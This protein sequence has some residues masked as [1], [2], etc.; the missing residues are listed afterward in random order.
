MN[1]SLLIFPHILYGLPV[2]IHL[3]SENIILEPAIEIVTAENKEAQ[4]QD[5]NID[6]LKQHLTTEK[7]VQ[8]FSEAYLLEIKNKLNTWIEQKNILDPETNISTLAVQ[9][10]IPQHHLSYYFNNI[11][12]I[13]FTDWRN[14]LK[15]D[16]AVS[17]L[18]NKNQKNY[19]LQTLSIQCGFLSQSTFI[20]AFKNAKGITPSEYMKGV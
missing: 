10:K 6:V 3:P 2:K 4:N 14:Q 13:K 20:R 5:K 8:L 12:A 19:T 7:Y 16:Y 18:D 11:L 1:I 15:I 9:I 17:L